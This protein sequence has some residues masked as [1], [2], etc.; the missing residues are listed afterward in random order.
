M[1]IRQ[2]VRYSL[3]SMHGPKAGLTRLGLVVDLTLSA[4][5]SSNIDS[6]V[7]QGRVRLSPYSPVP[8]LVP[9]ECPSSPPLPIS[10]PSSPPLPNSG[11]TSSL[12]AYARPGTR[13]SAR[14]KFMGGTPARRRGAL[15]GGL[16]KFLFQDPR[17]CV[18][19]ASESV[20]PD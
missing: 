20:N 1:T 3:C 11:Q 5:M 2:C 18:F 4:C 8:S 6:Q 9:I 13:V 12:A 16:G 14:K 19:R 17:R 15:S 10:A 7:L